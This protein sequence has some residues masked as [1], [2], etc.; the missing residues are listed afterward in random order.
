MTKTKYYGISIIFLIFT[1]ILGLNYF[2]IPIYSSDNVLPTFSDPKVVRPSSIVDADGD[3]IDDKLSAL[4]NGKTKIEPDSPN[5]LCENG[6]KVKVSICVNKKPDNALIEKLRGYGAEIE[7]I[8]DELIYAV[9]AI[10]PVDMVGIVAADNEVT[11]IQ[12][13]YYSTAHLDTSTVNMGA[14]GSSYVWDAIPTIKGNPHYSIAILDTGVDSTHSDMTNFLYFQDF[15]DDGYPSGSTGYDSAHHGTHCASIAAG[16]GSG[17]INPETVKQ[18][19]SYHFHSTI[20][21]YYT[22]HSFEIKQN[23]GNPDT[24]LTMTWDNSGG[25]SVRLGVITM[26]NTLV[27]TYEVSSS[28]TVIKNMGKMEPGWYRAYC[29]A[30]SEEA[31]EKAY[32]VQIQY[33]S[34]YMLDDEPTN[35]PVFAGI[36][37]QSNIVSLKV[38]RDAGGGD[39]QML[40]DAFTWISNN[41][42]NPAYNITTVSMSLGFGGSV[43]PVVDTA[44]NNLV[45]EG[46]ICVTSAGNGGT[47]T[48]IGSPG[49][50]QKCITV[51]SVNDAF[52]VVYYSSNGDDTY[53]KPDVIAPGGTFATSGS[54]SPYNAII[55]AD[56]NYGEKYCALADPNPNDYLSMQGTSMACPHIAGLAQLAIDAIIQTE[57]SWTW[58]QANALRVKQLICMGT[59]EV[60]AG[61]TFNGD[62]DG[63]PQNP[64]LNRIGRDN[65]EGYGM[66]RADAVIQAITHLTTDN[67]VNEPFYLNIGSGLY[68]KDS[69]VFLFSLD[70]TVGETYDFSLD[71]P[72]TGDFDLIIYD[73]DYDT[74]TGRPVVSM[75]SINSDLGVDE[76]LVFSPSDSGIYYWSIRAVEGYG[77]CQISISGFNSAPD[78][79]ISPVPADDATGV[80]I[81][82]TLSVDVSDPDGDT[83]DVSFYDASDDSLIGTDMGVL[84]GG[85]ASFTWLGLSSNTYYEWYAISDDGYYFTQSATWS[86]TTIVINTAPNAP[87]NPTP[88][89]SATGVSTNPILSVDVSDPDGGTLDVYFY[90]GFDTLIDIDTGVTSGGTASVSWLGLSGN[91]YYEW[92]AIADDGMYNTTSATWSFNTEEE[93]QELNYTLKWNFNF[94]GTSDSRGFKVYPDL[95]GDGFDD[96][97]VFI[98]LEGDSFY[99]LYALNHDGTLIWSKSEFYPRYITYDSANIRS[100]GDMS[101]Y[102]LF[103]DE[104]EDGTMDI[105]GHFSNESMGILDGKTGNTL[106]VGEPYGSQNF[107]IALLEDFT[108]DGKPEIVMRKGTY[109][110]GVLNSGD[111]T[112]IWTNTYPGVLNCGPHIAPIPDVSGDGI[113][114]IVTGA[115]YRD[116]IECWSGAD[117]SKIWTSIDIGYDSWDEAVCPDQNGDGYFDVLVTPQNGAPI[118]DFKLLSGANGQ[119]IWGTGNERSDKITYYI[120]KNGIGYTTH[121]HHWGATG[122]HLK[123]YYLENGTLI[124]SRSYSPSRVWFLENPMHDSI[125]QLIIESDYSF[126]IYKLGEYESPKQTI[127]GHWLDSSSYHGNP[128]NPMY[129]IILINETDISFFREAPD[130]TDRGSSYSGWL[131]FNRQELT[132]WCDV[133]NIGY[134]YASS[135]N[136]SYYLSLDTTI[137]TGDYFLG[138]DTVSFLGPG[139]WEGCGWSDMVPTYV[140]DGT[141]YV[142][143][144]IDRNNDIIESN[145]RNNQYCITSTLLTVVFNDPT[146]DT[147][148]GDQ[149]I[150][151]GDPFSYDVDASDPFGIAYYWINDETNFNID[152]NGLITNAV[153]LSVGE[154][155]LEIRAYDHYDNYCT[156]TIT[157]T[158]EDTTAPTWYI[159][160]S[161][162]MVEFSDPF[163]YDVDASDLSGIAYYWVD[164]ETNFNIN[165]NGLITNAVALS[166]GDY[167]LEI[168]AYD[169]NGHY[170]TATITI[171]VEDTTAPTWDILPSD[172]MVEFGDPFSYDVD[173]SDP[174]GIAYYWIDDE[175]NFNIDGNGLITNAVV[176]SVGDYTLE[177][178]AYDYNGHFCTATIT[179][180]VEDTTAPTWDTLPSDQTVEFGTPFSYDVDASDLSGIAY[181]WVDDETN[182]NIDGNGVLSNTT[183]L[184][185]GTYWLE[186]RAYDPYDNYCSKI[187]KIIVNVPEELPDTIPPGIPGYNIIFLIST[188][189][190]ISLLKIRKQIRKKH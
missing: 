66:V 9:Y 29:S 122:H 160:P 39:D 10:L 103:Y 94:G 61:E 93:F 64:S 54:S 15:T 146:W 169:Y 132:V 74:A 175:T 116:E 57:G 189:S 180:T 153:A 14:R 3:K 177:I 59:W 162:Q 182:F 37:P 71:V 87:T 28:S 172:Q 68:A 184:I 134:G 98:R 8:Y 97:L 26:D 50:A 42:K 6:E 121:D 78:A 46:F 96:I 17:D 150:E 136:V 145:E 11:F 118:G 120:D 24:I 40:L 137:T 76:S 109:D 147:L 27:G 110:F 34:D 12:K 82:P 179:I 170:C 125:F 156:A 77:T 165:G 131:R 53:Y 13:E 117:G 190:I 158:V 188:I 55:A 167:T 33:E 95:N 92:Y 100:L 159:L 181:Y 155:T 86:F 99:N 2:T 25:G 80:S 58:S 133:E 107:P 135:F 85:T 128:N 185:P 22:S 47:V 62:G 7:T 113:W 70:A 90:D 168:R 123:T 161:D 151:V 102:Y 105:I 31:L 41:G 48:P 104:N 4:I 106:W 63:I 101:W 108:G 149:T 65:V 21:W 51:G 75:S 138:I 115:N 126:G 154:Y 143:W 83:M 69:K 56:S 72:S 171:T 111:K 38:L 176:L 88:S 32:S 124:G 112:M 129:S 60:D 45:D 152:G 5:A 19:Y 166:V 178:R 91:T 114:D 187:I 16:T 139:E 84:S 142:G 49:T 30:N 163:S 36:A 186:L 173:A 89:D 157:I 144:I 43:V 44:V 67:L 73:D 174:S 23:S 20:G 140:P 183:I 119:Q 127:D 81:N 52:E 35:A 79:P 164:D 18:T 141:Y 1:T 130:L 148:P